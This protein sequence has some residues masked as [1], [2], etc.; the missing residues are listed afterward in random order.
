M[1][2]EIQQSGI[3]LRFVTVSLPYLKPDKSKLMEILHENG[4]QL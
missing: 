1:L 2:H 3:S 4:M